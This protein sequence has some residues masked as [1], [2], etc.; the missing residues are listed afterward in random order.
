MIVHADRIR[1]L[2]GLQHPPSEVAAR[3]S[4]IYRTILER[5][6]HVRRG[7]FEAL[8][9][10]DL[11]LLFD[12]YDQEFFEGLL[13]GMLF[14]DGAGEIDLRLSDRMTRAAGK[15]FMRRTR[16][17]PRYEIAVSTFLLFQTFREID[18]P[19]KVGG[20]TC[21]D[22][23][24]AL[25]RIF[26]HELLH[27]AEFLACGKSSCAAPPFHALSRDIF[28]HNG[29]VHD[30][31]TPREVA[32]LTHEIRLGDVVAFEHEGISHVGRVNRITKRAT[33]LVEDEAGRLYSD[34]RRYARFYVPL[35]LLR[36]VARLHQ[37]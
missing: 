23:L 28:G 12:L 2:S 4:R 9:I 36:K 26:E 24:E 22:R 25:L 1:R 18:R 33:I 17:G 6:A 16:T 8:G 5:S 29:V 37:A 35:T 10:S 7:N 11:R 34:G 31:V 15:T 30:L 32:A 21:R 14:E 3:T 20:I 27:L 13:T 19:V